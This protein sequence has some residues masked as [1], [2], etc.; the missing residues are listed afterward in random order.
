MGEDL[1]MASAESENVTDR[2]PGPPTGLTCP[3]CHG[4]IWPAENGNG[5]R[6]RVGH[7]YSEDA[8]VAAQGESVEAALWTALEVLEERAELLGRI[9]QRHVSTR[10]KTQERLE[11]AAKDALE[12]A[13]LIR[14]ALAGG[15]QGADAFDVAAD[16]AA[17]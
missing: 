6:C 15:A 4:A 14:R 10:P 12:R 13:E 9:A 11:N 7:A 16:E 2:P 8:F 5:F 1:T 17:G 3:E